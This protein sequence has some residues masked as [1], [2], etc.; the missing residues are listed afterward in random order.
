MKKLAALVAVAAMAGQLV[1]PAYAGGVYNNTTMQGWQR[2]AEP[3]AMAYFRLPFQTSRNERA[4]PSIGLMITGPHAYSVNSGLVRS[5]SPGVIDLA[6]TG[7]TLRSPWTAALRV[8]DRL[9]WASNPE[10]LPKDTPHLF[11][12]GTSWAVVGLVTVGVIAGI[13]VLADR[14][15]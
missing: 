11:E 3:A 9:A 4:K 2:T 15:K 1:S 8:N 14:G 7:Q 5:A 6:I 10:A 12:S 13:Y